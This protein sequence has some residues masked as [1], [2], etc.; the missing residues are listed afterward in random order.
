MD[1][2]PD[3]VELLRIAFLRC[4]SPVVVVAA[5][6]GEEAIRRVACDPDGRP[7]VVLLDWKMPGTGGAE[8]LRAIRRDPATRDLPVFV[9]SATDSPTEIRAAIDLGATRFLAK[10]AD[11]SEYV[12]LARDLAAVLCRPGPSRS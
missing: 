5:M 6:S 12:R 1:D 7:D 3:D 4:A 8:V 2:S 11:M 10:P 9:C